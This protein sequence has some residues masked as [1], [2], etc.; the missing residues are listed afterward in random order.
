[1]CKRATA[2]T[3]PADCPSEMSMD[4]AAEAL[5]SLEQLASS[6][7][8]NTAPPRGAGAGSAAHSTVLGAP[9]PRAVQLIDSLVP[10]I[11]VHRA[12]LRGILPCEPEPEA[13]EEAQPQ[14]QT[15]QPQTRAHQAQT[16]QAQTQAHA[17]AGTEGH[18]VQPSASTPA[19]GAPATA[20]T[21]GAAVSTVKG[22][23]WWAGGRARSA[24]AASTH[25]SPGR[26]A[27]P[28][29]A[30]AEPMA[31]APAPSLTPP[32]SAS[33]RQPQPNLLRWMLGG[34]AADGA[35]HPAGRGRSRSARS[36]GAA[37]GTA[38]EPVQLE[39]ELEGA[40][41]QYCR[42]VSVSLVRSS[43]SNSS[44]GASAVNVAAGASVAAPAAMASGSLA[45]TSQTPSE[46]S[47]APADAA[48]PAAPHSHS[49]AAPATP[50]QPAHVPAA[51]ETGM[52]TTTSTEVP[53]EVVQVL[54]AQPYTPAANPPPLHPVSLI[55]NTL[56]H[57][58][59][60]LIRRYLRPA[61]AAAA[62]AAAATAA[63]PGLGLGLARGMPWRRWGRGRGGRGG[64]AAAAEGGATAASAAANGSS[65]EEEGEGVEVPADA[66]MPSRLLLRV[67]LPRSIAAGLLDGSLRGDAHLAVSARS[68]F[69]AVA[70]VRVGVARH[71]VAILG[72]SPYAASLVQAALA[73]PAAL[74]VAGRGESE[75]MGVAAAGAG[76]FGLPWLALPLAW[77]RPARAA[78]AAASAEAGA[79]PGGGAAAAPVWGVRLPFRA[80]RAGRQQAACAA[81]AV[82]AP[83]VSSA[84]SAAGALE[85]QVDAAAENTV[86][87]ALAAI[88]AGTLGWPHSPQG[89]DGVIGVGPYGPAPRGY[90]RTRVVCADAPG[91]APLR[92]AAA[93]AAAYYAAGLPPRPRPRPG[94]VQ[95]A[96][97]F[98]GS[99]LRTK[100][101]RR[102]EQQQQLQQVAAGLA[103]AAGVAERAAEEAAAQLLAAS[104]EPAAAG[105][106]ARLPL[107]AARK[108]RASALGSRQGAS[109][110]VTSGDAGTAGQQA[111]VPL[112]L[113]PQLAASLR[114]WA[115][116]LPA[117]GR[118]QLESGLRPTFAAAAVGAAAAIVAGTTGV[119]TAV[120]AAA[121]LAGALGAA[122]APTHDGSA[123][124][125]SNMA[126]SVAAT[127][128]AT[129]AAAA[130][131]VAG[132]EATIAAATAAAAAATLAAAMATTVVGSSVLT[133]AHG[134]VQAPS[135]TAAAGGRLAQASS[136]RPLMLGGRFPVL[137]APELVAAAAPVSVS[138]GTGTSSLVT[139]AGVAAGP[140][141]PL[142][143]KYPGASPAP[144]RP[145]SRLAGPVAGA[146][147][148]APRWVLRFGAAPAASPGIAPGGTPRPGSGSG[149]GGN[150]TQARG[151]A[152][153]AGKALGRGWVLW[154]RPSASA[155]GS[156]APAMPMDPQP[157]APQRWGAQAAGRRVVKQ[158]PL[159]APPVVDAAAVAP[160]S[161]R[162]ATPLAHLRSQL[163]GSLSRGSGRA[164]LPLPP[165]LAAEGLEF[166]NAML[167]PLQPPAAAAAAAA[168]ATAAR[169]AVG[170]L[171]PL[172][173][174]QAQ[175]RQMPQNYPGK[176][177]PKGSTG[178]GAVA[179]VA[180]EAVPA[181]AVAAAPLAGQPPVAGLAPVVAMRRVTEGLR[182]QLLLHRGVWWR[183]L[184][185]GVVGA[186]MRPV[187]LVGMLGR[188][189]IMGL[190]VRA[191][192][193]R[194]RTGNANGCTGI[195]MPC[196]LYLG[197]PDVSFVVQTAY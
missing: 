27:A 153:G 106:I 98:S 61:D 57:F 196:R 82:G 10:R 110:A 28:A 86:A 51:P 32:S 16:H 163:L 120:G 17:A 164:V 178:R 116:V 197:T 177:Q 101:Q 114:A 5:A 174:L 89:D 20:A 74:A 166:C 192:L 171:R 79:V 141:G 64:A 180:V 143:P 24:P 46:L 191:A 160:P 167:E 93:V 176:P 40:N 13:A 31:A 179:P 170:L 76:L 169:P 165:A 133:G 100:S 33:P 184:V 130:S 105:R 124:V 144:P 34:A 108:Q 9:A 193:R 39:L 67:T 122:T 88:L 37:A 195:L 131:A 7:N 75:A 161:A 8:T 126:V 183:A 62:A 128:A 47:A 14:P 6:S 102:G 11:A 56:H 60:S 125:V 1:M 112:P 147:A 30:A 73:A 121:M 50:E 107:L 111:R 172:Q 83:A 35:G 182:R 58:T 19:M 77:S 127:V 129:A 146:G 15:H 186:L 84:A 90:D 25:V 49:A 138:N 36:R 95:T 54:Y 115:E 175:V 140:P 87:A 81:D 187:A 92:P 38:D 162:A 149:S 190:Q 99:L 136:P 63:A 53:C 48:S 151:G 26:A 118:W 104:S 148:A 113:P 52:S 71:R 137:R 23:S 152:G 85:A 189:P 18:L 72:T 45:A 43:S 188:L 157:A 70:D 94:L 134:G 78:G 135:T 194:V 29:D 65:S 154:W 139:G 3:G 4:G 117:L 173:P 42:K 66:A 185:G 55:S 158:Q 22:G 145:P 119:A 69:H 132:S 181:A 59:G 41:L 2:A 109:G 80:G 156:A 21:A 91:D 97:Q 12:S 123:A 150:N 44:A 103:G 96:L 68:D 142:P 168:I 159:T 155:A